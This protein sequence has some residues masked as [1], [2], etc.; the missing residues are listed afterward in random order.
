W[1]RDV[2]AAANVLEP[3]SALVPAPGTVSSSVLHSLG[4][5]CMESGD[6]EG[7]EQALSAAIEQS[8]EA[9]IL[10]LRPARR[11]SASAFA[12]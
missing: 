3:S 12:S 5:A 2:P 11:S 9:E 4:V 10:V 1:P 7:A 6:L 8:E